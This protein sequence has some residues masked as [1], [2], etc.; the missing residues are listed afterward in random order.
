M[1]PELQ[2]ETRGCDLQNGAAVGQL[3]S[4]TWRDGERRVHFGQRRNLF[5]IQLRNPRHVASAESQRA[6]ARGAGIVHGNPL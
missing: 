6:D 4:N 3:V 1:V 5:P 2:V